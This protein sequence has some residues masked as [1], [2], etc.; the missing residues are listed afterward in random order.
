MPESVTDRC[1]KSH[2]YVFLLSKSQQ[3]YFDHEA[4]KEA[5]I[6]K[7]GGNHSDV[8]QG[9]FND[10]GPIPGS[11][12]QSFRAIREKRNK[13][14]VWNVPTSGYKG[15]HFAVFPPALIRPCILAGSKQGGVVLDPFSGSGTTALVAQ[16]EGRG[17]I[18][19]DL[20][21]SYCDIA[22]KRIIEA[23]KSRLLDGVG[24]FA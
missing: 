9:G 5:A 19:I 3:Y 11:G 17:Y 6:H 4:I 7:P 10:K 8:K 1:T 21:P 23:V 24:V 16:N 13:R 20:N 22:E 15:A 2:E 14:N 12:Q 18:G